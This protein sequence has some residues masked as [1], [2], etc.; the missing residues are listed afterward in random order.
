[1]SNPAGNVDPTGLWTWGDTW[2]VVG[3]AR[4][5]AVQ[6][7]PGV[8]FGVDLSLAGGAALDAG[9]VA[10]GEVA[11]GSAV[12]VAAETAT[13]QA[14]LDAAARQTAL[15]AASTVARLALLAKL[16]ADRANS[17]AKAKAAKAG[18][19]SCSASGSPQG[20][21]RGN[22]GLGGRGWRGDVGWRA[23][24]KQVA[25][26]GTLESIGGTI[27]TES[28]AADLIDEGGGRVDRVEGPHEPPNPHQYNHINYT[29]AGGNRGTIRI[30]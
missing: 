16:A 3:G 17:E 18:G 10:G 20:P 27:P 25:Q 7:V 9:A 12:D 30:Q 5:V 29:T 11:G 8:D 1:M 19:E 22:R 23:A 13:R 26:G 21:G 15:K 4:L 2:A 28:E 24:V 14:A 6:F